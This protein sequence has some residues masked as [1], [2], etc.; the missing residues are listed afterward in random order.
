MKKP[1]TAALAALLMTVCVAASI[2]A[3]G[4]AA[5][6]NK[7][8]VSSSNVPAQASSGGDQN[9]PQQAS[10]VDQM[11][12]LIAQYQDHEQQYQQR[13]QQLQQQL[14]QA[15]SQVQVDQQTIQ[16]FQALLS[17]LQERGVIS[18]TNDGR[19]FINQ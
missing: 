4:G 19:V 8:G 15:T 2:F 12:Q 13:E 18:I 10:Q 14:A 3:I 16:Q 6:L 1:I 17:A 11:Q 7:N 5:M 9:A